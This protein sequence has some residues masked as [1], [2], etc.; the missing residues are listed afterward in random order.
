[1]GISFRETQA[2]LI[3]L[4][5]LKA[6]IRAISQNE[7]PNQNSERISKAL[8]SVCTINTD[9]RQ[10]EESLIKGLLMSFVADGHVHIYSSFD[11]DTLLSTA[12]QRLQAQGGA[13]SY[14]LFTVEPAGQFEFDKIKN[15]TTQI[16]SSTD[17]PCVIKIDNLHLIAGRQVVSKERLEFL[18][19]FC[20]ANIPDGLSVDDLAKAVKKASGIL[21]LNWAPGKWMFKRAKIVKEVLTKFTPMDLLICDTALRFVFEPSLMK[22]ARKKGFKIIAGSDPFPLP[23]EEQRVGQYGFK[24]EQDLDFK[25][26]LLQGDLKIFGSRLSS[27]NAI[28]R[29][30]QLALK[31]RAKNK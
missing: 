22:K 3:I 20:K 8:L 12:R 31:K 18:A 15:R 27:Y 19:L 30:L 11:L 17:D 5:N 29:V 26:A 7:I 13:E 21:V 4:H 10:Q 1:M 2:Q 16:V 9:I 25:T 24:C 14:L 23:N 6:A 28:T